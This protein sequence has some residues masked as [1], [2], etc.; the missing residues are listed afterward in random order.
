MSYLTEITWY[1]RG[2]QGVVTAGKVLA[3]T[4]LE[5]GRY[6]QSAPEYGPERAGAPIRAYTRLSDEPISLHSN[7]EEPD[8]VV[9][10]DPTVIGPVDV[11]A[12]LKQDGVIIVNT[13]KTPAEMRKQLKR[14]SGRVVTIDATRIAIDEIGRDITN[15]PL[16][17][18]FA[19]V[20][21]I[22]GV[23]EIVSQ[24]RHRFGKKLAPAVVDANVR[25][26]ERAANEIKVG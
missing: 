19:A 17:G 11:T 21:G 23:D 24:T 9:V 2:G 7:I 12:G 1:G 26:I 10:L 15:T 3:E 8:I 20:T 6:F 25:A 22:F 14:S 18:A 4:A 16:L 13:P 5:A